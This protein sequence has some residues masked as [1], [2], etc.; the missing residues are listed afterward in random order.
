MITIKTTIKD[1]EMKTGLKGLTTRLTRPQKALRECGLVFLRSISKTFK[2]GG[3]PVRWKPSKRG[4]SGGKT[5]IDTARL[6]RSITMK[7]L[8]K[9]VQWG[10]NVKYAAVQHLGINKN[11][12]VRQH[13]RTM[14]KA[15]GKS[16]DGRRVL[17]LA[18]QR[19]MKVPARPFLVIQDADWRVFR[20]I[21]GEYLATDSHR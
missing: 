3:R 12:K 8:S 21:F 19:H 5:L 4:L 16:I 6:L 11:V 15:F 1:M 7:V 14:T 20:K 17:V 9:S 18:H 13:W 2:A 10:T